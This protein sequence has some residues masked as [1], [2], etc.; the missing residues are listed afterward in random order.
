MPIY[1]LEKGVN[2][3]SKLLG[4]K[5]TGLSRM[6]AMKLPVPQGFIITTEICEKFFEAGMRLPDG[7]MNEVREAIKE[8]ELK[9]GLKYGDPNNPLLVSVRSGSSVSMPGVM[10]TILNVGLNEK[11]VMGLASQKKS[12]V[13]G[14]DC[15]RRL[16]QMLTQSVLDID[17]NNLSKILAE[18]ND[19][20][21]K[22]LQKIVQS[23]KELWIEK[24]GRVFPEDPYKQLELSIISVLKSWSSKR[25]TEYRKFKGIPSELA[26]GTAIIIMRMVFGN[27]GGTSMTGIAFT[28]NPESGEKKLYGEYFINAQGDELFSG[29]SIPNQVES[30]TWQFPEIETK[31]RAVSGALET[32]FKEPQQIEFT[33]EQNN[34]YLLQTRSAEMSAIANVKVSVD[35]CHEGLIDRT[36]A[37]SRIDPAA[38]EQMMYPSIENETREKPIALGIGASPGSTCGIAVFD[39]VTAKKLSAD[40]EQIILVREEVRPEDVHAFA[41][42]A[43]ILTLKGGKTSHAI[44]VARG[45]GKPCVVGCS[46]I[47]RGIEE[48]YQPFKSQF[49]LVEGQKI[50]IDGSTGKVYLG[51]IKSTSSNITKELKEL[52]EWAGAE[53]NIAIRGNAD[54][55]DDAALARRYGAEGIGLCRTETMFNEQEIANTFRRM[56]L[57]DD[58]NERKTMLLELNLHQ[59]PALQ[60]ILKQMQGLP[61]TFRLL[62]GPLHEFLPKEEDLISEMQET[63]ANFDQDIRLIQEKQQILRR[64]HELKESNPMLGHRGVRIGISYPEIYESQINAICEATA[65]LKQNGIAVRPQIMIPQ[66]SMIQELKSI[67]KIFE[68][69]KTNVEVKYRFPLNIE[70]GSMIEVVRSCLIADEISSCVDF[71]SFGTN[72]LTQA[73]FSF[74]REDAESRFLA[75]YIDQKIIS[76]N[77]FQTLDEDGVG[78][79]MKIATIQSRQANKKVKIG[80]CGEHGGDPIS[81][82]FFSEIGLDYISTSPLRIP[83]AILAAAQSNIKMTP[84]KSSRYL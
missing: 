61:V 54:T 44:V 30:L 34:L 9:V 60:S 4:L 66:V 48:Q 35:L 31:L 76:K 50:T 62:D 26:N 79:L 36:S 43:G 53:K 17:E 10:A 21:V 63:K 52:L 5:G 49:V 15:Y 45:M 16:I 11:I 32:E 47:I 29:G 83:I 81:I 42:T 20:D 70:F 65:E 59:R 73:T 56:I 22:G 19:E 80:I 46:Q 41:Y 6:T 25:A 72:D 39:L 40:G 12:E 67:R 7:L 8:L 82:N 55:P 14:W 58:I 2:E 69:V 1:S 37:L 18:Y 75:T 24:T 77:P 71:M 27:L 57:T 68:T 33:V 51:E 38:L 64:V 84:I 78:K 3:G 23:F 28:R 13:F 74:S